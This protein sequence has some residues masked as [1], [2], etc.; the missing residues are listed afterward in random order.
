MCKKGPLSFTFLVS[1]LPEPIL[2]IRSTVL[3]RVCNTKYSTLIGQKMKEVLS[4]HLVGSNLQ[5][6]KEGWM[7]SWMD[8]WNVGI[9]IIN[10][11]DTTFAFYLTVDAFRA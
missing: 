3:I 5:A 6:R 2:V 10:D 1:V 4:I 7:G 8:S 9:L 11:G